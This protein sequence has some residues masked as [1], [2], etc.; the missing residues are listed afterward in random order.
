MTNDFLKYYRALLIYVVD[1]GFIKYVYID[2]GCCSNDT[3]GSV[4]V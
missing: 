1:C 2:C 3:R 4:F